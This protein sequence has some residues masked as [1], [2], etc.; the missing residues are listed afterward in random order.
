MINYEK[1]KSVRVKGNESY[2]V[3]F[4]YDKNLVAMIKQT[5]VH[6]WNPADKTW[7]LDAES[8]E[9][10]KAKAHI[11]EEKPIDYKVEKYDGTPLE[12]NF[13]LLKEKPFQHQ[14]EYLEYVKNRN[15]VINS[16][17][18]GLGKTYCIAAQAV[19]RKKT[20]KDKHCLIITCVNGLKYNWQ[21]ELERFTDEKSY[22]L[23]TRCRKDGRRY[24]GGSKEKYEDLLFSK[25]NPSY[26]EMKDSYF[27][28]INIEA[29]RYKGDTTVTKKGKPARGRYIIAEQIEKLCDKEIGM[30][31]IDE[32]HKSSNYDAKQTRA[33]LKIKPKCRVAMTG[34]LIT[35]SPLNAWLPLYWLGVYE[36]SYF[37]F[38]KQFAVKG[39]FADKQIVG[40]KNLDQLSKMVQ[41]CMFRRMKNDVLDLPEK[42]HSIEYIELSSEEKRYYKMV[43]DETIAEINEELGK[44]NNFNLQNGLTKF[45]RLRQITSKAGILFPD[46]KG[47]S[48]FERC[49]ELVEEAISNGEKV[50]IFSQFTSITNPLYEELKEFNPV[51][52]TGEVDIETRQ[53]LI[54]KF[55]EDDNCKVFIGTSGAAGTGITITAATTCILIDSPWTKALKNQLEDRIYRIGQNKRV[56]II[57]LVA[58]GTI[59]EYIYKLVE[60]KG[61][62]SSMVVDDVETSNLPVMIKWLINNITI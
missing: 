41:T 29:L 19:M 15:N 5:P 2:F 17:D 12:V 4:S 11:K 16:L 55:Q 18:Q 51:L 61:E 8:F 58:K 44:K 46:Y 24:I 26:Q 14:I 37:T 40:F 50:A 31:A 62:L 57:D 48:K 22:I 39:G 34:T 13:G 56:N 43:L 27:W 25:S 60:S 28:I 9:I 59:D 47:S 45:L 7:E 54:K 38:E 1:R 49:K 10:F 3:S 32:I 33:L 23:G 30:V 53:K 42:L 36:H 6:F 21:E 20:F 35:N 52:Y